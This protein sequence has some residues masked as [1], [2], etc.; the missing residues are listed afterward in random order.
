MRLCAYAVLENLP[1]RRTRTVCEAGRTVNGS[2]Y[3]HE[4]ACACNAALATVATA[5][6]APAWKQM[7]ARRHVAMRAVRHST[8]A[9]RQRTGD[10]VEIRPRFG[11]L[12]EKRLQE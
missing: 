6:K 1:T 3:G 8:D 5:S 10:V 2:P 12:L 9:V 7:R 11:K 4:H